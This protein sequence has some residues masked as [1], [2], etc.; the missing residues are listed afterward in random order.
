MVKSLYAVWVKIDDTLPWIE[1]KEAFET[2]KEAKKT[3]EDFLNSVR[4]KIVQIPE[5][6]KQMKALATIKR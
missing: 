1:L 2:R 3:A 4:M 5:K 6:S